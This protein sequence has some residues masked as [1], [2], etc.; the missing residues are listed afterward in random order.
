MQLLRARQSSIKLK[1]VPHCHWS[2]FRDFS[3]RNVRERVFPHAL[4]V[5]EEILNH[6]QKAFMAI[7][8]L[9]SESP[10][11][12]LGTQCTLFGSMYT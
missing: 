6:I 8:L 3:S 1:T 7:I 5:W 2:S 4:N 11:I 10:E 12:T 9:P